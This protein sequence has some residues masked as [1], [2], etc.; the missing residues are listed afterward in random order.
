MSRSASPAVPLNSLEAGAEACLDATE[1]DGDTRALLR[2]LGLT[3]ASH[4]RVCK[5]GEPFI[6][7]VR[8]T[9]IGVSAAVAG[10]LYVTRNGTALAGL[11]GS[12]GPHGTSA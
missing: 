6:F 7:Q 2:S 10:R 5:T 11:N 12:N 9:R 3:D 8:A 1:L 4:L